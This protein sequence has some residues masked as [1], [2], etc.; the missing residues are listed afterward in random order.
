MARL[1]VAAVVP[2]SCKYTTHMEITLVTR[3]ASVVLRPYRVAIRWQEG[4]QITIVYIDI[5]I[6]I[7][8]KNALCVVHV[9]ASPGP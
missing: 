8:T 5:E 7:V 3:P 9:L 1:H 2:S 4:M 6:L